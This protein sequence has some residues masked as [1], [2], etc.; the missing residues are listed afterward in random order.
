MLPPRYPA[1][2]AYTGPALSNRHGLLTPRRVILVLILCFSSGPSTGLRT[3]VY[4]RYKR[5]NKAPD[6]PR[7]SLFPAWPIAFLL[8]PA[9]VK[10]TQLEENPEVPALFG[11]PRGAERGDYNTQRFPAASF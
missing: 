3:S 5:D 8:S 4:P 10:R 11:E 9:Y 7:S 1:G 6:R 2:S